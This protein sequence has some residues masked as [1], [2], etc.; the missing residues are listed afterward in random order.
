MRDRPVDPR[1]IRDPIKLVCR[2]CGAENPPKAYCCIT[3]FKVL[4]PKA[5]QNVWQV[6]MKPSISITI[7]F[8]LVVV[9][10][11]VMMKNWVDKIEGRVQM[12]LKT[13]DY[14][15]SVVA[16]KKKGF[17][18]SMEKPDPYAEIDPAEGGQAAQPAAPP[19]EAPS[20]APS[21]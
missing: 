12:D 10:G 6:A 13:A 15:I 4:R 9:F 1:E 14:N 21:N 18:G 8:A 2:N 5:Q 19:A 16:N 17:L 20:A 11:L 7:F 3:C